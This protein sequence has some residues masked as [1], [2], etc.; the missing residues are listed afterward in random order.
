MVAHSYPRSHAVHAGVGGGWVVVV[1]GWTGAGAVAGD[2]VDGTDV[3]A[4]AGVT[5]GPATRP[6][7]PLL[8]APATTTSL[9]R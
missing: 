9:E 5:I 2:V 8:H 1:V 6:L 4:G 3:G 7:P